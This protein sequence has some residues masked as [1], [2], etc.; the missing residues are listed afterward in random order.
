MRTCPLSLRD[1]NS[2]PHKANI[3]W[4]KQYYLLVPLLPVLH[5]G[6][7]LLLNLVGAIIHRLCCHLRVGRT[8]LQPMRCG[9]ILPL[10][11]TNHLYFLHALDM[12]DF[13][14]LH[15]VMQ[16][17]Q[18]LFPLWIMLK[19]L[20]PQT[21]PSNVTM[22]CMLALAVTYPHIILTTLFWMLIL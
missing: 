15:R 11:V 17:V 16:T 7:H 12:M 8:T 10:I 6:S 3:T 22:F 14:L 1:A 19:L 20:I 4:G 2:A 13:Q 5:N 9:P 21:K 18:L